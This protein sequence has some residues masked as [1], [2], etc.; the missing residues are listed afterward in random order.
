M[1][2]RGR[3]LLKNNLKITSAQDHDHCYDD[4]VAAGCDWLD[5]Y[6]WG[7]KWSWQDNE[8]Q[9]FPIANSLATDPDQ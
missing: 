8:V 3:S 1:F 6:V 5:E 9:G 2:I 7:Y 4:A